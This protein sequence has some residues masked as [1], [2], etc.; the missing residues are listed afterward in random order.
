MNGRKLG[1]WDPDGLSAKPTPP[2]HTSN[3]GVPV[4]N[5]NACDFA[6]GTTVVERS[7]TATLGWDIDSLGG[8][9]PA[10]HG[11]QLPAFGNGYRSDQGLDSVMSATKSRAAEI[12]IGPAARLL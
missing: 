2:S 3:R 1:R 4:S 7:S 6:E 12:A 8:H 10:I 9:R 5:N 11:V